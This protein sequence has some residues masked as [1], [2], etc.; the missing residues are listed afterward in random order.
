MPLFS[1]IGP[2]TVAV[3]IPILFVMGGVLIA[4]TAVIINGRNK[5]LEHRERIIAMEKGIAI[6]E[7]P[8]AE[9][10]PVHSARRAWGLVMSGIGLTL[11][12]ALGVSQGFENG[13]W[14]LLPLGIGVGLLIAAA[15][16]KKEL[17][18]MVRSEKTHNMSM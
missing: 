16:D 12:I 3:F 11:T 9:K 6:P 13:V 7:P 2:E 10:K 18:E 15:L 5:D 4:V 8:V 14:G 17:S 1:S